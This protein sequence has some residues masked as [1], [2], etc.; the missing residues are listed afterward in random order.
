MP[1]RRP[2]GSRADSDGLRLAGDCCANID[3]V[4]ASPA[5]P[6]SMP[7]LTR[8]TDRARATARDG[9]GQNGR[10]LNAWLDAIFA[11]PARSSCWMDIL[12]G[13]PYKI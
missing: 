5:A 2:V 8:S 9:G 10:V 6:A 3:S 1:G 13:R 12:V 11:V 7:R 4:A